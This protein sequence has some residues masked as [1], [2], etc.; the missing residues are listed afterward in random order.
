MTGILRERREAFGVVI[1]Q[2]QVMC[3]EP[4]LLITDY[5]GESL[6]VLRS[7]SGRSSKAS[8]LSLA[9]FRFE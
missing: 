3:G 4:A 8:R 2:H 9:V 6:H 1:G 5:A 7:W